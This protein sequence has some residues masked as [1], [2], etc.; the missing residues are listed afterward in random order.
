MAGFAGV[1]LMAAGAA[2]AAFPAGGGQYQ[3]VQPT[4]QYAAPAPQYVQPTQLS[5]QNN[6]YIRPNQ[7]A[8]YPQAAQNTRIT[9]ALPKVGNNYVS[10]GRQYYA[11]ESF[12]RLADSGLYLGLSLGYVY[13]VDGGMKAEY[14]NEPN[15]WYVPGAFNTAKFA[16]NSVIPV[17]LSVGASINNDTRID[18]SYLRYS[19]LSYPGIVQTSDGAGG[20]FDVTAT[21]GR[22]SSTATML[23]IYYNLDSYTGVLASGS[24]RPYVGVGLGI[25][26]NTISD[27]LVY[28]ASFYPEP[29]VYEGEYYEAGTLTAISDIYAYHAGGTTEQMSYAI[30]VGATTELQ[31]GLKLDFFAR[32]AN[33]GKVQSSGSVVVSQTEWLAVS[34]NLA[35]GEAG[36]EQP[37]EYDSVFHYTNWKEGGNLTS[38]DLGV[39]LRIQF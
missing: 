16:H 33:L 10:A 9:G 25:S 39:R 20:Y 31:G 14:A 27:Y 36:S 12:D 23:N 28:D 26:T 11:P 1:A 5:S 15:S 3:Y 32:W 21:D 34:P 37:A 6:A 19:G 18:F 29:G 2:R 8:R 30:E 13:S 7:M 24:L 38:L 4:Q 35:I 17:Q 22:V